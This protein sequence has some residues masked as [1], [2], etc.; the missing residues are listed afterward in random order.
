MRS[1]PSNVVRW[2]AGIGVAMFATA[3]TAHAQ[4]GRVTVRVTDA[5]NQ[6]PVGQ[7]QVQIVGTTLGG[8]TGAEG[9]FTIRGLPPGERYLVAA[10]SYLEDGEEQDRRLL[11]QLRG[12]ATS[13]TLGDG[14]QRSIQ[15]ELVSR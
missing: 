4:G 15:V 8:L 7:A 5:A 9:R 12:R 14:E 2:A 1:S 13:V 10:I 6:Q 3:F 11:Q